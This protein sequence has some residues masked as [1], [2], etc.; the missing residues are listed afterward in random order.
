MI[1][2]YCFS[3]K[4]PVNIPRNILTKVKGWILLLY[5]HCNDATVWKWCL[6]NCSF[7]WKVIKYYFAGF[8]LYHGSQVYQN[9]NKQNIENARKN[10][11]WRAYRILVEVALRLGHCYVKTFSGLL[12][13]SLESRLVSQV[14]PWRRQNLYKSATNRRHVWLHDNCSSGKALIDNIS[15]LQFIGNFARCKKRS[16]IAEE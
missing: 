13:I 4:C 10:L 16:P 2:K 1:W 12:S 3:G 8:F 5:M 11:L 15:Q 14:W 9:C 7:L 6:E